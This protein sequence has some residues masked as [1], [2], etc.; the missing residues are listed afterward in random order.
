[1]VRPYPGE[2]WQRIADTR[3]VR[4][5]V[6]QRCAGVHHD[7][8]FRDKHILDRPVE[9]TG[10]A[11]AGHVPASRYDRHFVLGERATQYP[12]PRAGMAKLPVSKWPPGS[13]CRSSSDRRHDSRR[14]PVRL[15]RHPPPRCRPGSCRGRWRKFPHAL[16]RVA[17]RDQLPDA[18]VGNVPAGRPQTLRQQFDDAL[19]GQ[20]IGLQAAQR[21]RY[22]QAIKPGRAKFLHQLRRQPLFCFHMVFVFAELRAHGGG[23]ADN[24]LSVDSGGKRVSSVIKSI[25]ASVVRP[26]MVTPFPSRGYRQPPPRCLPPSGTQA[27]RSRRSVRRPA[28]LQSQPTSYTYSLRVF[29]Q[30][31]STGRVLE[32][33]NSG[34][35]A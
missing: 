1:M 19:I 7:P 17:E 35:N 24:R 29:G 22:H 20:R 31:G 5:L 9:A 32:S 21:T 25:G 11:H 26:R 8:A 10:A 2:A 12:G 28:G 27:S 15:S 6:V 33:L 16:V 18:I 23:G 4:P 13:R 14:P 30:V 34:P 3:P